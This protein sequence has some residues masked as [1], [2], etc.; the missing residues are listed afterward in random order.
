MQSNPH[1]S[2]K[3]SQ[4]TLPR[5]QSFLTNGQYLSW[6]LEQ[7]QKRARAYIK[8]RERGD[9]QEFLDLVEE[10]R[11]DRIEA[12]VGRRRAVMMGVD[13]P[14]ERIVE[15]R[16]LSPF[17]E[18]LLFALIA[19][20][21]SANTN[22][23]MIR[24]QGDANKSY[25]EFGFVC[26]L[27][28]PSQDLVSFRA[29]G[30]VDS[31]LIEQGLINIETVSS[32]STSRLAESVQAPHFIA[33][34]VQ[35]EI[36]VDERLHHCGRLRAAK[37]ALF[38]VILS[39]RTQQQVERFIDSFHPS[40]DSASRRGQVLIFG[41]RQTGKSVL[42]EALAKL[43]SE[44]IFTLHCDRL[45]GDP[46]AMTLLQLSRQNAYF[47][48]SVW[49]LSAPEALLQGQPRFVGRLQQL[50][51]GYPGLVILEPADLSALDPLLTATMDCTIKVERPDVAARE[52]L[53]EAEVP[54]DV[55]FKDDPRLGNLAEAYELTGGQI[56]TAMR[57]A[58]RRAEAHG[59]GEQLCYKDLEIGAC[60][61]LQ[62]QTGG[63]TQQSK[64]R[65]TRKD[66]ILPDETMKEIDALLS[67][68][69]NR[70]R[71]LDEWGFGQRLATGRGLVALFSGEAGTG[72]TL[73]AEIIANELGCNLQIV[74]IPDIV[75]KWI[76]E[77]S[78]N[79]RD[80][81]KQARAQNAMLL[82]DEADALFGKRVK[83]ERSQD[84]HLNT[85]VNNLLQEIER[86]DGVVIMTTNLEKN[87]DPAFA[88]R[89]LYKT[90]FP[91][92]A[93]EQREAL[94]RSLVPSQTPTDAIDFKLLA[95]GFELTG[96]RIKN[97]VVR[98]AYRCL[99]AD[100]VLT[101]D[102][103]Y[104]SACDEASASGM[105]LRREMPKPRTTQSLR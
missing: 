20:H 1:Q 42:A 56:H 48:Q 9:V 36:V 95:E 69:R 33:A 70:L 50:I 49:H 27:L 52:Q 97:A 22:Q 64:A 17:D 54:H 79:I 61:Q 71:L 78:Q 15:E 44:P 75:S 90:V 101:H 66:L 100:T 87:L 104:D 32:Q 31:P 34:A 91:E 68:C 84:H 102:A 12:I 18:D 37:Q 58:R 11:T 63:L 21:L 16:N 30:E 14:F 86:F 93:S 103:L 82:F 29:W 72:K 35:G 62:V 47:Y 59:R 53:W 81:F 6:E 24:A 3:A 19:P 28:R 55:V 92:P 4:S 89:I 105:L 23:L 5:R 67:A 46:N 41:E 74:S 25:L 85:D 99:D 77:T 10:Q 60:S 76:G 94:W 83:V 43:R 7:L 96:G 88:R 80:V 2:F 40:A 38:D 57:W 98:A 45:S 73:T 39:K 8:A 65:L 13:I 26:D 51:Q